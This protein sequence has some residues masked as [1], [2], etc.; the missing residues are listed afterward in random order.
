MI[1]LAPTS[2]IGDEE[3][4]PWL[5]CCEKLQSRPRE[6]WLDCRLIESIASVTDVSTRH[7]SSCRWYRPRRSS[8]DKYGRRREPPR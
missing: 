8:G 3:D 1:E 4:R 6:S 2:S 7:S 5:V